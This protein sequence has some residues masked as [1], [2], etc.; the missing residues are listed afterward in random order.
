[1]SAKH[2]SRLRGSAWNRLAIIRNVKN[3]LKIFTL[4]LATYT[5]NKTNERE[6]T[7]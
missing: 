6:L 5:D 4:G 2:L 1:M 3:T 7:K